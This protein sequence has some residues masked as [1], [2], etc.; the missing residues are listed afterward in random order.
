MASPTFPANLFGLSTNQALVVL[1]VLAPFALGAVIVPLVAWRTSG[2]PRPMLISEILATGRPAEAE[3]MEVRHLGNI[4]DMK[5][6]IRF[7]LRVK[8]VDDDE[9]FDLEVVQSF[10]RSVAGRFRRGEFVEVRVSDD[11]SAGAIV[12]GE[13]HLGG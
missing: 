8:V 7:Q 5:P 10:P 11:R 6:M 1:F 13:N 9:A 12:W 4:L 2:A 3:I